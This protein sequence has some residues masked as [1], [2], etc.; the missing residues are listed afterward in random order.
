MPSCLDFC[1]GVDPFWFVRFADAAFLMECMRS[2]C[3]DVCVQ[4]MLCLLLQG[5]YQHVPAKGEGF[6][7]DFVPFTKMD[8]I[9]NAKY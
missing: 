2:S 1:I 6:P 4:G 8:H 3:K 5:V 9:V 7:E